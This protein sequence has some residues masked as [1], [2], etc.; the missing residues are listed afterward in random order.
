MAPA[1][2]VWRGLGE[3]WIQD[4]KRCICEENNRI[5]CT[6]C[7]F[8]I[9]FILDRS[10]SIGPYGMYI[11]EKY[12]ARI[13]KCL[14]GLDADVGYIVFDCISKWLISLGLYNVDTSGLIQQ[15]KAAEFTGGESRAGNAIRYM[16]ST[17]NYRNGIPSAAVVL[18]DGLAYDEYPGDLYEIQSDAARTMG[19]EL[20][21]VAVGRE[22]LFNFNALANIAGGPDRVF[23]R[24]SCCALA[25]RLLKDLCAPCPPGVD[26][27][28][29][30]EDPCVTAEC[31]AHPTAMCKANYC[32][33]CNAVFYDDQGDKVDCFMYMYGSECPGTL[34]SVGTPETQLNNIGVYYGSWYRDPVPGLNKGKIYVMRDYLSVRQVEVYAD[35]DDL[36]AAKVSRVIPLP[37]EASGTGFV[38]YDG[39]L[40]YNKKESP[41]II[42]F[43]LTT[44]NK[45]LEKELPT[46]LV[47]YIW[48]GFTGI[49]FAVDEN[50]LWVIY[51]TLH[52]NGNIVIAKLDPM[53][54]EI[55]ETWETNYNKLSARDTFMVCG[56]LYVVNTDYIPN[57]VGKLSYTFDTS[58]GDYEYIDLPFTSMYGY[59]MQVDYNPRDNLLYVWDKGNL[60]TYPL[61]FSNGP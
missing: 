34:E 45:D 50:G 61:T 3:T 55:E 46:N 53:S 13:I 24:Y 10:S 18:T 43:N 60:L 56:K 8:D 44:L 25:I 23:D 31:P 30:F 58:T 48:G 29:C 20:Y 11:A 17:A 27:V 1:S 26:L 57:S 59:I 39:A 28:S 12:I 41:S 36:K 32:G 54:L 7:S 5:I 47:T 9:V 52:S 37:D 14:Y 35:I 40:Y 4:G 22:F 33:G 21:A 19:I 51:T 42:K 38:V 2:L 6:E 49:D 16:R 15:I